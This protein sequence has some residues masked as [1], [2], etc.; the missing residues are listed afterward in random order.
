MHTLEYKMEL[1]KIRGVSTEEI[2]L[3]LDV[4]L[5]EEERTKIKVAPLEI[6]S[7]RIFMSHVVR[8]PRPVK[9]NEDYIELLKEKLGEGILKGNNNSPYIAYSALYQPSSLDYVLRNH[10]G[11]VMLSRQ[12]LIEGRTLVRYLKEK[13]QR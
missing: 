2:Q 13:A 1:L 8:I 6:E 5:P 3:V 12:R 7:E 4:I 11:F 9:S 10:E